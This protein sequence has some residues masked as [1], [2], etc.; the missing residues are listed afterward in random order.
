MINSKTKLKYDH[1]SSHIACFLSQCKCEKGERISREK[2][3][4]K[5][6][7]VLVQHYNLQPL[8]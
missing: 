5:T 8:I 3:K 2:E 4:R 6:Q 1:M 7:F